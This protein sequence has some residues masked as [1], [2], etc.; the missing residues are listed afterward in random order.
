MQLA[1]QKITIDNMLTV[2]YF[3]YNRARLYAM[4]DS[5]AHEAINKG[6]FASCR[7]TYWSGEGFVVM[8]ILEAEH[9][10]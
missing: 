9:T 8:L 6:I 4:C 2:D 3:A 5:L 7:E 10:H 1:V